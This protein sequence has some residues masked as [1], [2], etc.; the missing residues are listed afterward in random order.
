MP[1]PE[2]LRAKQK[3]LAELPRD[4]KKLAKAPDPNATTRAQGAYHHAKT[5]DARD[6][7]INPRY[8][9]EPQDPTLR[10]AWK[11]DAEKF[12]REAFPQVFRFPFC[13][14]HRILIGKCQEII[15]T[16]G[17]YAKAMWRGGGKT[18]IFARMMLWAIL[19]GV[20]R[21]GFIVA[22][23][24]ER[25]RDIIKSQH[26]E[27]WLNARLAAQYPEAC[28]PF[29]DL[30]NDGKRANGQHWAGVKTRIVKAPQ[31]LQLACIPPADTCHTSG[32]KILARSITA[33]VRGA[34]ATAGDGT[35]IRPDFVLLDDV[36]NDESAKSMTMTRGRIETIDGAILG[37]FG[38]DDAPKCAVMSCTPI[39]DGDLACHYLSRTKSPEWRGDTTALLLQPPTNTQLWDDYRTLKTRMAVIDGDPLEATR[40]YRDH[41]TQMDL[42]AEVAWPDGPKMGALSVLQFCMDKMQD[43]PAAFAAEYQC[44]PLTANRGGD[45]MLTADEIAKKVSGLRETIVPEEADFL[46]AFVDA[47]K[48]YLWYAVCAWSKDFTGSCI[49]YGAWPRQHKVYYT[50]DDANPTIESYFEATRPGLAGANEATMLAAALD[51]F[52]PDLMQRTYRTLT[53]TEF[54]IKR[55]LCDT[56]DLGDVVCAAI[57]RLNQPRERLPIV[58]PSKG[59]GLKENEND[60]AEWKV[61]P[62][63]VQG[64]HWRAPAP[65]AGVLRGVQ[66][67]TNHFKSHVHKELFVDPLRPGSFTLWGTRDSRGNVEANHNMLS[68]HLTA[69]LPDRVFS[70]RRQKWRTKWKLKP[71]LE[72]EG[73]DCIVG[74]AVGASMLGAELQGAGEPKQRSGQRSRRPISEMINNP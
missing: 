47:G 72:N 71:N 14:D 8:V 32:T 15:T 12:L 58:M 26:E 40:F 37:L 44:K 18:S 59:F 50:K 43:K 11:Q 45:L 5:H 74:C 7:S 9:W 2:E 38:G 65:K 51:T 13:H 31:A 22:A 48:A 24:A 41:R 55:V 54:S 23:E 4:A 56:G 29:R 66:I 35:T 57:A 19:N 64:W 1:T 17:Q 28:N 34:N 63:D 33:S 69:E 27:L 52:L 25:S 49:E 53:G 36:Q 10:E 62:G 16:G 21:F 42:G 68:H 70:D 61:N 39:V 73:L 20:K 30:D 46:T 3:H 60:M 67:D 6:L